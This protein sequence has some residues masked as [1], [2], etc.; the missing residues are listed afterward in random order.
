MNKLDGPGAF[1]DLKDDIESILKEVTQ[2]PPKAEE[3]RTRTLSELAEEAVKPR[4]KDTLEGKAIRLSI[5]ARKLESK[6]G[7]DPRQPRD[8]SGKWSKNGGASWSKLD[9]KKQYD[10]H[11]NSYDAETDQY[12]STFDPITG[13]NL[14]GKDYF[15]VGLHPDELLTF[16]SPNQVTSEQIKNFLDKNA[17]KFK[18][19]NFA[20][21]TWFSKNDG[22]LYIDVVELVSNEAEARA[23]AIKNDQIGIF[24]LKNG[25]YIDTGG[26]GGVKADKPG[27]KATREWA[28]FMRAM[29]RKNTKNEP[30]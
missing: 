25:K 19:G 6:A 17:E 12:G 26:T 30:K 4:F 7:F 21:G 16:V 14:L 3:A 5:L 9:P 27:N 29:R 2:A 18:S 15:S 23:L 10:A 22:G 24:D 11:I 20:L 28:N 13:E 8:G 1:D